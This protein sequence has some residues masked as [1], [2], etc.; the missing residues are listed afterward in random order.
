MLVEKLGP[1]W[2]GVGWECMGVQQWYE[3]VLEV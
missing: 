2:G 3:M 1:L